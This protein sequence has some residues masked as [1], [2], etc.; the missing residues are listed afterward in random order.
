[1]AAADGGLVRCPPGRE[2]ALSGNCWVETVGT[3]GATFRAVTGGRRRY[4]ESDLDYFERELRERRRLILTAEEQAA[5]DAM[6]VWLRAARFRRRVQRELRPLGLTFAQW[7]FL[8]AVD[9]LVRERRD[10]VS[11]LDLV[12]RAEMDEN[13]TSA[14]MVRLR[15]KGFLSY[16]IDAWGV[17]YR[18]LL[19]DRALKA[20]RAARH[21]V[22]LA[23]SSLGAGEQLN[24]SG[25]SEGAGAKAEAAGAK[26]IEEL[27]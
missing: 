20:L 11:Q 2:G 12:G 24:E 7:R 21:V 13:T 25:A 17:C 1:M 8:D 15:D 4:S 26:E 16:D 27:S 5:D 19:S 3:R 14:I 6:A 10:A 23:S 22:V 9:R 18:I